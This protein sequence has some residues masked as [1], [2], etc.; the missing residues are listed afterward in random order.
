MP[1]QK[2]PMIP[3]SRIQ[4]S[5][6]FN[7]HSSSGLPLFLPAYWSSVMASLQLQQFMWR[8]CGKCRTKFS[9]FR[10][11][12]LSQITEILLQSPISIQCYQSSCPCGWS[13][14]WAA[15]AS[16]SI[17][18][19]S[20]G[21][22]YLAKSH[23]VLHKV[24]P[25]HLAASIQGWSWVPWSEAAPGPGTTLASVAASMSSRSQ[26]RGRRKHHIITLF[27]VNQSRRQEQDERLWAKET[28]TTIV[29]QSAGQSFHGLKKQTI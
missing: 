16:A 15:S 18:N 23:Q 10:F 26:Q 5:L 21:T 2:E 11:C 25:F 6:Q 29:K 19:F 4:Y 22:N 8:L 27:V 7:F 3:P 14:P 12:T 20:W 13:Q 17:K 9:Y 28:T 1:I 24:I